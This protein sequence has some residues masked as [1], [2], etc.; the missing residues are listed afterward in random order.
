MFGRSVVY[1]MVCGAVLAAPAHAAESEE[2][3]NQLAGSA[4]LASDYVY[5]GI[6]QSDGRAALMGTLEFSHPLGSEFSVFAGGFIANVN[7]SD[8]G[9]ARVEL[10]PYAGLKWQH[11]E[12]SWRAQAYYDIFPGADAYL[13]YNYYSF[14]NN[15]TRDFGVVALSAEM[16]IAPN[17]FGDSGLGFYTGLDATIPLPA[18]P[19]APNLVVHG[20][21][22]AIERNAAYGTPDYMDWA[23]E[24]NADIGH[25]H[26]ALRYSGT[27]I[28]RSQCFGGERVCG[29]RVV[30]SIGWTF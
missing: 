29:N 12:W 15:I 27:D 4:T 5:R 26:L 24:T 7:Y 9:Q 19:L 11:D 6:S 3:G 18:L 10:S 30:A 8:G 20:G 14:D 2:P 21:R 1:A 13:H 22:Q 28:A 25:V 17:L 23:V 16:D